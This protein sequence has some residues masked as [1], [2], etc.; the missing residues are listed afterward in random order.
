MLTLS[1]LA[2]DPELLDRIADLPGGRKVPEPHLSRSELRRALKASA[3]NRSQA[4]ALLGI[5]RA[6]LFR[7]I[8]ELRI[9]D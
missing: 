1:D 9:K 7:R 4:A 2:K 6:T 5:S 8:R 3:G